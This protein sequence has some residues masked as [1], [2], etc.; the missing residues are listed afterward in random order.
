MLVSNEA[1]MMM[2]CLDKAKEL[3]SKGV[4]VDCNGPCILSKIAFLSFILALSMQS[5]TAQSYSKHAILHDIQYSVYINS[6]L[7]AHKSTHT[8]TH[9]R[10]HAHRH[11][12]AHINTPTHA[13]T[14]ART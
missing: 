14:H 13:C 8:H 7:K 9:A 1:L 6:N 3:L 4:S 10:T 2:A 12:R 11:T 5:C